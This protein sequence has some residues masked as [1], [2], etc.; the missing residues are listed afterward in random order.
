MKLKKL[1]GALCLGTLLAATAWPAAAE[2]PERRIQVSYPW[3]PGAP[4][5]VV[6]QLVADGMAETLGV[7]IAVVAKS[8]AGG[9]NAIMAGLAEPA[10]GYTI[11]DAYLAPLVIAPLFDKA[12]FTYKEFIP[13]HSGTSNAFAIASRVDEDRWTDFPSF[14]KYLQDH[15]GETRFSASEEL[16]LPHIVT[17]T[18]LQSQNAVARNVPYVGLAPAMKDLRGGLL[19]WILVNPGVYRSNKDH[20][21]ILA[22][23]TDR[24]EVIDIYD[25]A[26]KIKDFGIETGVSGL[27]QMGWDWWVVA[28]GTPDDAVAKLRDAMSKA[29]ADPEI[30]AKIMEVG[31]VPIDEPAD[32]YEAVAGQVEAELKAAMDSVTW[33]RE[34]IAKL[35]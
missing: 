22:V 7:D 17:S 8:G 32:R 14:I 20:I 15:P 26:P 11:I 31:F 27:S 10:D 4:A 2:F 29:L 1:A 5:Y 6:S 21:K 12:D 3:K 25:G 30:R 35:N 28:P 16:T 19:D 13:L 18:M 33:L 24:D 34:E 9:V 23:F